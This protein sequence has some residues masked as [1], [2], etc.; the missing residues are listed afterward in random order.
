M[1]RKWQKAEDIEPKITVD[2]NYEGMAICH[3]LCLTV[4]TK[5]VQSE[6]CFKLQG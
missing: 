1:D 6:L 5:S 2:F 3:S 4:F